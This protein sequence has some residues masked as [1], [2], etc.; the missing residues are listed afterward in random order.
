MGYDDHRLRLTETNTGSFVPYCDCGWI[1]LAHATPVARD[2][3]GN[4]E[5]R[6]QAVATAEAQDEYGRHLDRTRAA[7]TPR[8]MR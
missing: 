7:R 5:R 8:P 2:K 1:S 3:H 4:I 6:H